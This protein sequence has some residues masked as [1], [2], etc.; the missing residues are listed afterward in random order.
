VRSVVREVS[1][2]LRLQEDIIQ[3]VPSAAAVL[4]AFETFKARVAERR[5]AALDRSNWSDILEAAY[6]T[7]PRL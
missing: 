7:V 1:S 4:E 3:R 5:L 2:W 6:E